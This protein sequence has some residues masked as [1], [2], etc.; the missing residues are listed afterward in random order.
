MNNEFKNK[1]LNMFQFEKSRMIE[2]LKIEYFE[3]NLDLISRT[4][5]L[6]SRNH[7]KA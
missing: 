3:K 5:E 7:E 1:I 2:M 6:I 4:V